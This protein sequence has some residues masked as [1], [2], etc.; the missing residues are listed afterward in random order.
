MTH[1]L[2]WPTR[3]SLIIPADYTMIYLGPVKTGIMVD[4]KNV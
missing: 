3:Q 2:D 1:Y 4:S